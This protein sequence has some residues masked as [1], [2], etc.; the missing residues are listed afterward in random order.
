M[1][2]A[3]RDGIRF[4]RE[5]RIYFLA[6]DLFHRFVSLIRFKK[7]VFCDLFMKVVFFCK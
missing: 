1:R 6:E 3:G 7:N 5:W 4:N 2:G